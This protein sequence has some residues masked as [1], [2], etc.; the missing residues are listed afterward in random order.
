MKRRTELVAGCVDCPEARHCE[1][2][3]EGSYGYNLMRTDMLHK[4]LSKEGVPVTAAI[5]YSGISL[6]GIYHRLVGHGE[7]HRIV[8]AK[9]QCD[10]PEIGAE[11][12]NSRAIQEADRTPGVQTQLVD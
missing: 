2:S 1:P 11:C 4:S 6:R 7:P 9:N 5:T 10:A 8:L 12:P 3:D